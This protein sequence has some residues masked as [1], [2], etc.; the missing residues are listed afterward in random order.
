M[1]KFMDYKDDL[2]DFDDFEGDLRYDEEVG[3]YV[4]DTRDEYICGWCSDCP[5]WYG[6]FYGCDQGFDRDDIFPDGSCPSYE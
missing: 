4:L 1:E 6:G 2:D 3:G 5:H